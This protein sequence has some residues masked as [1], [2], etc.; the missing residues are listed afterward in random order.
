M[1]NSATKFRPWE[2]S[3]VYAQLVCT[4]KIKLALAVSVEQ[5]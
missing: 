2:I 1:K 5:C 4:R 3:K